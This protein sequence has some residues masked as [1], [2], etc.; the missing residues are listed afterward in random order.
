MTT[1]KKDKT[2]E[3]CWNMLGQNEKTIQLKQRIQLE[4]IN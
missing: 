2:E 1:S 3:E 4:E